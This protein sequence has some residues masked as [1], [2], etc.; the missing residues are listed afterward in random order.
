MSLKMVSS[1]E[2]LFASGYLSI[3]RGADR[4]SQEQALQF[5]NHHFSRGIAVKQ[6]QQLKFQGEV[7]IGSIELFGVLIGGRALLDRD[8]RR[9]SQPAFQ[10]AQ[11][12][13]G[14]KILPYGLQRFATE[15]FHVHSALEHIIKGVVM[16]SAM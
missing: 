10:I 3:W 16:P 2:R 12:Q 14:E 9:P 1:I 4:T 13:R 8:L 15:A 6:G 11:E 7:G 5:A